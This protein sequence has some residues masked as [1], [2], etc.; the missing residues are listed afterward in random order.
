MEHLRDLPLGQI[1]QVPY[2]CHAM[3]DRDL[4]DSYYVRMNWDLMALSR[5]D[6]KNR[7]EEEAIGFLQNWMYFGLLWDFFGS[8]ET[9]DLAEFFA[10]TGTGP[11]VVTTARL[12]YYIRLWYQAAQEKSTEQRNEHFQK[13]KTRLLSLHHLAAYFCEGVPFGDGRKRST[14]HLP[15]EISLSIQI[16]ADTLQH[17]GH[18]ILKGSYN[19]EWGYSPLLKRNMRRDGWCPRAIATCTSGQQIHNL[20]YASTLGCPLVPKMHESCDEKLCQW[21]QT[22]VKTYVTLHTA[23]CPRTCAFL[24]SDPQALVSKYKANATPLV[25]FDSTAGVEAVRVTDTGDK[26]PYV[27]I[28]HVCKWSFFLQRALK[29]ISKGAMVSEISTRM[30]FRLANS[31]VYRALLTSSEARMIRDRVTGGAIRSVSPLIQN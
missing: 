14:W 4:F 31:S 9:F 6:F 27:A 29:L 8:M 25:Y 16:L 23:R 28:S 10:E 19:I 15:L 12:P 18:E 24:S 26:I 13:T 2:L 30:L 20:Y 21:E 3:Y 1:I 11:K 22:D 17:A 5:G 7:S